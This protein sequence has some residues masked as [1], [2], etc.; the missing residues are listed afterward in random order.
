MKAI[1]I[2]V[3]TYC[4]AEVNGNLC[5]VNAVVLLQTGKNRGFPVC[6][7]HQKQLKDLAELEVRKR[8]FHVEQFRLP[9]IGE[10]GTRVP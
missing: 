7:D 6:L 5:G 9:L 10:T 8:M 2:T 3:P 4:R 1:H